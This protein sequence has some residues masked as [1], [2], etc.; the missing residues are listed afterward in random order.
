MNRAPVAG[1]PGWP[2]AS[3]VVVG[4]I[5]DPVRHS[6]SPALHNAAFTAMALDWVSVAFPVPPGALDAALDGVR[7]L[8]VRGLSVTMPF[9]EAVAAK[10]DRSS[11]TAARL[12]AVNCVLVEPDGLV[13]DNT[14][15]EG[16]LAAL[17]RGAQ[18]DPSGRRCLVAG[19]GGAARAVVLAL[20]QAGAAEVVVVGRTPA[21][22]AEAARLAGD[23]GRTGTPADAARCDLVV[24]ATPLGMAGT[25]DPHA[26]APVD[27]ALLGPAQLVVDLVYVPRPTRWL[28]L[29][30]S[31]G[32]T[33]LDGLGMLV[34]QAARQVEL[35]AGRPAPLEAM[36]RA[37]TGEDR[38]RRVTALEG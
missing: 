35:W 33:T 23:A 4:V 1:E 13:G 19:A 17:A 34:H 8:G 20:A 26:L 30:Q 31:R 18:F 12:G 11:A 3:S 36:W 21:R 24:N 16:F 28:A 37:A 25:S 27:P 2:Q 9:K 14:D 6:L 29:A 10:V 22:A 7:A 5:G 32:A 15:G 38:H